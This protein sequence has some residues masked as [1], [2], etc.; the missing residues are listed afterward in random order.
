[1]STRLF[2]SIGLAAAVCGAL[3]L[4]ARGA[5]N[6][7]VALGQSLAGETC[8]TSAA[9]TLT[10]STDIVCGPNAAVSGTVRAVTLGAA[11]SADLSNR[12]AAIVRNALAARSSE[13]GQVTCDAGQWLDPSNPASAGLLICTQ[14]SNGWPR[15]IVAAASD[16][17]LYEAEG[18][19]STLPV[20]QAAIANAS[21]RAVSS[22]ESAT[23]LAAL[24]AKVSATVLK[25]ASSDAASYEQDIQLARLYGGANNYA[26]AENAYRHALEVQQRLFG[27]Q[28]VPVGETLAEL[29]L[30][31]SNQG[32]FDEAAALFQRA[33]PILEGAASPA[34]RAR[35]ASYRALDAANQ[36]KFDVALQYARQASA[37][38]R[39][40]VDAA[41]RD[42][43]P[44]GPPVSRGE[45]AHSL[46][47]EA[48]M[49][50]R[51][52]DLAGA[53]AA[54][55][56]S[57]WIMTEEPGLPL[58]WRPAV[59]QTMGQIN[60]ADGRTVAAERDYK[61]AVDLDKKLF[62]A[63]APT[64][65]AELKLGKFYK[66]QQVY[67]PALAAYREAFV[68]LGKDRVARA[69]IVPDQIV[70]YMAAATA[71]DPTHELDAEVFASSQ[72]IG[73]G[74]ADQTIARMAAREAAGNPALADLVRQS[75]DATRKRDD[76]RIGL[77]AEFAKPDDERNG[78]REKALQADLVLASTRSDQ[79]AQQV[80]QSYPDYARLADPG[81]ASLSDVQTKLG[82]DEAFLSYVIGVN[83]SFGLLVTPHG[84]TALPLDVRADQLSADI[85][86]L[87]KAF[88]PSLGRVEAFS[89]KSSYALYKELVAPF[90]G[91]LSGINH[92]VVATKGDLASLPFALLVTD[93]PSSNAYT[94]AAWLVRK[95]AL[96]QVPS[97]R[98]FLALRAAEQNRTAPPKPFLAVAAPS[99]TGG[100]KLDAFAG[101]CLDNGPVPANV[102]QALPPLPETAGEANAVGHKLGAGGDVVLTGANANERN[103]RQMRLDQYGVLYFATHGLLPGE[104]HCQ[105]E[106]GLALTPISG[107]NSTADDGLLTAGEI[108][109]LK[110]NADLVVLS[111]CNTAAG[112]GGRFGGGAL[113]GLA[114]AFFDAGARA[115]VASHWQVPSTATVKLMTGMFDRLGTNRSA[116][117]AD[118][119]R[120]SQLALIA[121]PATAHPFNWAAFTLIGDGDTTL[122]TVSLPNAKLAEAK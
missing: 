53:R 77:A 94:D 83:G 12:R 98:A 14:Q 110:L 38:R 57:L 99:F 18:L 70:P 40:E 16:T 30:Q 84:F 71:Q 101:T 31:V 45:L 39:A 29:A 89:T 95:I 72:M 49:A 42:A 87:R 5:D 69:Q 91:K 19:P 22:A 2:A 88:V 79:L 116:G 80:N 63:T 115:V 120:Q 33:T 47:I 64:A 56:E 78:T 96:S 113:E 3:G 102:L 17:T 6:G 4:S 119:L 106:P 111:A 100:G 37:A 58:W 26:G 46:R 109:S 44:D 117:L 73:S 93:A 48:E 90:A 60:E 104:L 86:D 11:L 85:A 92:L 66:G 7:G 36:R 28:S 52:S 27:E 1:M 65:L 105:A 118:A 32:R 59:L 8:R 82:P 62:G 97:A 25:T 10:R 55:E 112:G 50:L 15:I 43:G 61:D 54:A 121:Q 75:Q 114:D 76:I 74:V 34:L 107:A 13:A 122:G 41:T 24:Q 51:L 21:G 81:P 35:L 23:A 20:L 9:I 68:I 108:A 103:L 67:G